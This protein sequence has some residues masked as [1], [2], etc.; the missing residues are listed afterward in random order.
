MDSGPR[1]IL[2][3]ANSILIWAPV[4]VHCSYL[5]LQIKE[6]GGPGVHADLGI[7]S[8]QHTRALSDTLATVILYNLL[9]LSQAT[10]ML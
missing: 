8:D 5:K 1:S 10:V 4:L 9:L 2:A 6:R 3:T 7:I